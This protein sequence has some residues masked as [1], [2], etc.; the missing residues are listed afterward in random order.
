MAYSSITKPSDYFNTKLYTGNGSTQSITG[1]GF[2][3]DWVWIK[4]RGDTSWHR[5]LDVV[6]GATKELYQNESSAEATEANGLTSFDSNGFSIGSNSGY[7]GNTVN[8]ASWNW[9]AGGTAS[10]NTDGSITS[11]VSANTTSGFSI[12]T[13]TGSGADATVGHGLNSAPTLIIVKNR[14]DNSTDWRVG[15]V[16]TSSNNMT[17]GNGYY[18]ELNDTK[19]STNPGSANQ[20]GS[21][22]TAP[23]N[24]VFTVGSNN[25]N[26]GS[27]D[28]MI[29][30]CFHSVK[31]Y[32]KFG[33]YTGNGNSDG[34]F[35]YTGFK[36]AWVICKRSS[37]TGNWQ[38]FDSKR[39]GYNVDNDGL[40]ANL[41]NAEATDDDL[42]I[43]SNGFKLRGSGN[44]LNGSGST[45]IYMAF[46]EEP[47]VANVG[48]SIPATAR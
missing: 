11:T 37:G 10:S 39:E 4:S 19:A 36:P 21:T 7:N 42:D 43:L 31:G 35:V 18:L 48:L 30:Y 24:Q 15:Q 6:R 28:N 38:M 12:V 8:F 27:S 5:S 22:P 9:L 40:Q 44:D 34:T 20:W 14:T 2:Q 45:Y 47:L 32:S 26:N 17:N 41:S 23:T 13:W 46:A 3:P 33:S 1:V 29:A 25:S 16:L